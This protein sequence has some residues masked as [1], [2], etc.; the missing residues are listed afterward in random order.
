MQ[1]EIYDIWYIVSNTV[2]CVFV[3]A[4]IQNKYGRFEMLG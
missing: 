4:S 3:T 2:S 1:Y